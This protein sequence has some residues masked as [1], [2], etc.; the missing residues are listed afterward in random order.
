MQ[1]LLTV[2][3][4][5]AAAAWAADRYD[6]PRPPKPDVLYLVHADNLI[7]TEAAEA[8]DESKKDETIYTMPGLSS[9]ARTP[10]A[11]PI[12]LID[13]DRIAPDRLELYRWDVK[14]GH[15]ELALSKS[16]RKNSNNAKALHLAVTRVDGNLYRVEA[17]EPL[18]NGEYS[19]SPNDSNRVFC[20]EVF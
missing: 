13:A 11:E 8:K 20:F 17:S 5:L 6:G 16:R 3:L 2:L 7:P 14:N 1:R 19:I 15:R 18:E 10:L 12:F 9:P 4:L